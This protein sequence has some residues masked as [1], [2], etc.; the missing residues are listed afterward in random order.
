MEFRGE[1]VTIPRM[2][3]YIG[4]LLYESN[5]MLIFKMKV[6]E[7]T[8]QTKTNEEIQV[9]SLEVTELDALMRN[10]RQGHKETMLERFKEDDKCFVARRGHNIC[11]YIWIKND[12]FYFT[13]INYEIS[14]GKQNIWIYDELVFEEYRGKGIQQLI[15]QEIFK[16]CEDIGYEEVFVGILSDNGPSLK[17][18]AKFGFQN[19][20]MNVKMLRVM[21]LIKHTIM[22][23]RNE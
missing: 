12:R 2:I 9:T 4:R 1:K 13:E 8:K 14:A 18:H 15:L 5:E 20:V 10:K 21:G 16:F 17:A 3:N 7:G 22:D 23:D 19:Q 11:G 6:G